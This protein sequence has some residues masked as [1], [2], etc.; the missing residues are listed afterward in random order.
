MSKQPHHAAKS[1]G[2]ARQQPLVVS[3][4]DAARLIGISVSSLRQ[5]RQNGERTGRMATPPWIAVG[6]RILYRLDDL[7]EFLTAHRCA[8]RRLEGEQ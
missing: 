2:E 4:P 1:R 7:Q 8:P 3:E 6:R 5:G